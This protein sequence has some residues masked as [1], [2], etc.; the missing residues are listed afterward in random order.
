MGS[1]QPWHSG[2]GFVAWIGLLLFS[3]AGGE[4]LLRTCIAVDGVVISTRQTHPSNPA[5]FEQIY[6]ID[7]GH[8]LPS[9]EYSATCNS[10]SLRR[11]IP[12]GAYIRK[13]RWE[14]NYSIDGVMV[15]DWG[16]GH[17]NMLITVSAF[18]F[19]IFCLGVWALLRGWKK[20]LALRLLAGVPPPAK[21]RFG[22]TLK[23]RAPSQNP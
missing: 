1:Q 4:V 8:G 2:P 3:V 19:V 12:V 7:P 10:A 17:W 23:S 18:G 11:D 14:R 5:R 22:F 9:V 6:E 20:Q 13:I 15:E 21:P 16:E